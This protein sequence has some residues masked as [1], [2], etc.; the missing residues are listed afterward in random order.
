[1]FTIYSRPN[2]GYCSA[3]KDLLTRRGQTFTELILDV[4]QPKQEGV[5]YFT[6]AELT[7]KVPNAKTVP[8]IFHNQTYIGGFM[9][10]KTYLET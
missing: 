2:C 7:E 5:Q 3:A 10:L 9:E 8:Q 4:G 6:R 1:M